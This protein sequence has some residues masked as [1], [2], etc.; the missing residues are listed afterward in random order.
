M[1]TGGGGK[2]KLLLGLVALWGCSDDSFGVIDEGS[3]T[4]AR[5]RWEAANLVDYQVEAHQ[6]CFC[7]HLQDFA[8]LTIRDGQVVAAESL[9]SVP[10]QGIPLA[11]WLT[12]PAAFDLIAS[13]A[14]QDIYTDITAKYDPTLGYPRLIELKCQP[15]VADCGVVYEFRNLEPLLSGP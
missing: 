9:D 3:L 14:K 13:A 15:N 2:L 1:T 7:P 10:I 11:A 5:A 8:R 4:A 12:V 6:S